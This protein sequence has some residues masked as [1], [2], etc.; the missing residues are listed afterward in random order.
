MK[1]SKFYAVIGKISIFLAVTFILSSYTP[2]PFEKSIESVK[3]RERT[4]VVFLPL[5]NQFS[6]VK[7]QNY[8]EEINIKFPQ[9]VY[10]QAKLESSN[11]KS[12]IFHE[13]NNFFGMKCATKRA[14]MHKGENRGHAKYDKWE[15]C[16]I[17]YAL[18]QAQYLSHIKTEN[19]YFAYLKAN[20]A[21]D[22]NYVEKLKQIIKNE[23]RR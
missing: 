10:A 19:Q 7:L 22:P 11:F 20:Y 5:V 15:D 17:D 9:I 18:Y 6:V 23:T 16:V 12:K 1:H 21:E 13:N 4:A 14:F 8:L 3:D 2:N